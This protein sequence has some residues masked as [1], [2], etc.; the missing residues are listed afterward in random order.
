VLKSAS[1]FDA[2]I[3]GREGGGRSGAGLHSLLI[4]TEEFSPPPLS[5]LV[6]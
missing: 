3:K 1:V 5:N 2:S 4:P 6:G